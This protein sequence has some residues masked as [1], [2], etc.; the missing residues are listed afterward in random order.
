MGH[1]GREMVLRYI[2]VLGQN[3]CRFRNDSVSM[4]RLLHGFTTSVA[5]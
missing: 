5:K 3:F 2:H 4:F 1:K